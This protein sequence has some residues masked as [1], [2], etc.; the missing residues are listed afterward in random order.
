M[1]STTASMAVKTGTLMT[2]FVG[3]IPRGYLIVSKMPNGL[4]G[5]DFETGWICEGEFVGYGCASPH[6]ADPNCWCVCK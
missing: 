1:G 2:G 3:P 6:F 5:A 4:E